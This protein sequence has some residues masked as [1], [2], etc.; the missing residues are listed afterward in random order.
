[1]SLKTTPKTA[2]LDQAPSPKIPHSSLGEGMS[3][4][5][6]GRTD[7]PISVD[8]FASLDRNHVEICED[9]N[10]VLVNLRDVLSTIVSTAES[11]R[12][13][14]REISDVAEEQSK[15]SEEQAAMLEESAAAIEELNTSVQ[16]TAGLAADAN[17]HIAENKKLAAAGGEVVNRTVKAMH[18]IE[19]S[20]EQITAIIGVID[21]I[22][23]QTNLLALNA[24]VEAARAG[25]SG[26]GFAVVASEVRA[27]A[28]RASSSANEIKELILRS[29]GHVT[30]GS[31]LANQAG[32]ALS[33]IIDGVNHLSDL[34]SNIATG[35]REQAINLAEIKESVTSLDKVTQQNAVVIEESSSASRSLSNEAERMSNALRRFSVDDSTSEPTTDKART[36]DRPNERDDPIVIA[37]TTNEPIAEP[38]LV[39]ASQAKI[40]RMEA[41]NQEDWHDF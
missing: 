31:E 9:F 35:S 5:A 6:A 26:R 10:N 30:D 25:E 40:G 13:S 16:K 29:S 1:M 32:A 2:P 24:G 7:C 17:E 33:E 20:S 14:S 23:F 28:Q 12:T 18:D 21:D 8:E 27:L 15:R 38:T 4:L 36:D 39:F 37:K 34:V 11:V 41:N 22:A 3:H 19:E